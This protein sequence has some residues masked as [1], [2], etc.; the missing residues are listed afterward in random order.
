RTVRLVNAAWR[1]LFKMRDAYT[2]IAGVEETC[3]TGAAKYVAELSLSIDGRPTYVGAM[4]R[5][6]RDDR[7][8]TTR[9]I[10]VCIDI[11][12]EVLA[13]Q[14][15]ATAAALVWS[16]PLGGEADY[17]NRPWAAYAGSD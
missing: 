14:L 4:L 5:P 2:A 8:A 9:V 13:A 3:R 16:G 7:G 11:T 15:G 10:A 12:D 1:A 6:S 17:F